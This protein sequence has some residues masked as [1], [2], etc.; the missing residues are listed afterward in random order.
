VLQIAGDDLGAPTV[1]KL[2][3]RWPTRDL[4]AAASHQELVAFARANR[5]GWPDRLADK[6]AAALAG[7][8]FTPG[9]SW[10]APRP[11]PS[12]WPPL[13]CW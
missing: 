1:L 4:L 10:C 13:S 3:E 2:L 8:H 5:H 9:P 12:A 7:D 11:T 6:V